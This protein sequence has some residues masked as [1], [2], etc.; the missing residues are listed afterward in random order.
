MNKFSYISL[1][2]LIHNFFYVLYNMEI[3]AFPIDLSE[4]R[5]IIDLLI[6]KPFD[7]PTIHDILILEIII[8]FL[9]LAFVAINNKG[10]DFVNSTSLLTSEQSERLVLLLTKFYQNSLVIYAH[11]R[12]L[13]NPLLS[14]MFYWEHVMLPILSSFSLFLPSLLVS[15]F[16]EIVR[17]EMNTRSVE[18]TNLKE[19]IDLLLLFYLLPS[20]VYLT[21]VEIAGRIVDDSFRS[22][23]LASMKEL[24]M[25]T[26][27]KR[28]V[29]LSSWDFGDRVG[30]SRNVLFVRYKPGAHDFYSHPD[31]LTFLFDKSFSLWSSNSLS[32]FPLFN[33]SLLINIDRQNDFYFYEVPSSK[34]SVPSIPEK[35]KLWNLFKCEM[36]SDQKTILCENSEEAPPVSPEL[37]SFMNDLILFYSTPLTS[38]STSSSSSSCSLKEENNKEEV[39]ERNFERSY[40]KETVKE[41]MKNAKSVLNFFWKKAIDIPSSV[42]VSDTG[43]AGSR[44]ESHGLKESTVVDESEF[45][46]ETISYPKSLPRKGH[47]STIPATTQWLNSFQSLFLLTP[48]SKDSCI[49]ETFIFDY[50][51]TSLSLDWGYF[52]NYYSLDAAVQQKPELDLPELKLLEFIRF[53]DEFLGFYSKLLSALKDV[54][55]Y[56]LI[57]HQIMTRFLQKWLNAVLSSSDLFY[58]HQI[59]SALSSCSSESL[60]LDYHGAYL[61]SFY[62]ALLLIHHPSTFKEDWKM[63]VYPLV[64]WIIEETIVSRYLKKLLPEFASDAKKRNHLLSFFL[65]DWS[66]LSRISNDTILLA[67]KERLISSFPRKDE[68]TKERDRPNR[69]EYCAKRSEEPASGKSDRKQIAKRRI[70]VISSCYL[71]NMNNILKNSG[72]AD[73]KASTFNL[74]IIDNVPMISVIGYQY[75]YLTNSLI[76]SLLKNYNLLSCSFTSVSSVDS[77][78]VRNYVFNEILHFGLYDDGSDSSKRSFIELLISLIPSTVCG[79][80]KMTT[81][82]EELFLNEE[83]GRKLSEML[84]NENFIE[85]PTFPFKELNRP[86]LLVTNDRNKTIFQLLFSLKQRKRKEESIVLDEQVEEL[87]SVAKFRTFSSYVFTDKLADRLIAVLSEIS[88]DLE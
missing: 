30:S 25:V 28:S 87:H 31:Q 65:S 43:D 9:N 10:S 34:H 61:L 53:C 51:L 32:P 5:E 75:Q 62:K 41:R 7:T 81:S 45:D 23:L 82:S 22:S 21:N 67:L 50:L 17:K 47:T 39:S 18:D 68:C 35:Q 46:I 88:K 12:Q 52:I 14:S 83:L 84:F 73:N 37:S 74:G 79:D 60:L 6:K 8:R 20:M 58:F 29:S 57:F 40:V 4:I 24:L 55:H 66:Y 70:D 77:S 2:S 54:N 71:Q 49:F 27:G 85:L 36:W 69:I 78:T 76:F 1:T 42:S 63:S 13:N 33:N 38:G 19:M 44:N 86:K 59:P 11:P 80:E 72:I 64:Q 26:V 16:P 15:F 56:S 48:S 3:N